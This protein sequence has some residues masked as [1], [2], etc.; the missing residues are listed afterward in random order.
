MLKHTTTY[1][2]FYI[3]SRATLNK[4]FTPKYD[5]VFPKHPKCDKNPKF[6]PLSETTSIPTPFTPGSHPAFTQFEK[7][8]ETWKVLKQLSKS[9]LPVCTRFICAQTETPVSFSYFFSLGTRRNET[10]L[11]EVLTPGGILGISSDS[12]SPSPCERDDRRIVLGGKILLCLVD[13][14]RELFWVFKT[15]KR[16]VQFPRIPAAQ[17]LWKFYGSE[18]QHRIFWGLNFGPGI[19]WGFV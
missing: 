1:I 11:P 10:L 7:P 6:T 4:T 2:Y 15:I 5:G 17:F 12:R 8:T 19:F 14:S 13:L 18:I 16:F 3:F 9:V